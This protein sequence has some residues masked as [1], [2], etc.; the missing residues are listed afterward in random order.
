MSGLNNEKISVYFFNA[1]SIANKSKQLYSL[2]LGKKYDFIFITET[3]LNLNHLDSNF[4]T[5]GYQIIRNDRLIS[6]G[7]GVLVLYRN[8]YNVLDITIEMVSLEHLCIDVYT[9]KSKPSY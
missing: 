7:G 8:K 5:D 3:W 1:R 4:C 2:M 6:T 9:G